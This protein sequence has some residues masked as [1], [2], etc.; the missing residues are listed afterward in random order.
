MLRTLVAA[1]V[2]ALLAAVPAAAVTVTTAPGAPDPGMAAGERLLVSFDT[3]NAAGVTNV[4]SGNVITAAGSIGGVRAAP[5]GTPVGNVYQSI[6]N[7][8]SSTFDFSQFTAGRGLTSASFYWGSVDAFNFVDLLG[9]GGTVVRTISG[10]NLPQSNGDQG[11]ALTNRRAFF[12][13]APTETVTALRLRSTGN[14]FEFDNI[15]A[16][17]VPEPASWAML[18]IGFGMIGAAMR[19][20][21]RNAVS[22]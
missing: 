9:P 4:T 20:P 10:A 13:F 2:G 3:A 18:I 8:G 5:A 11:A 19:R 7:G 21:R 1:S 14:A 22:A 17:P 6:G 16:A 15:S 12:T